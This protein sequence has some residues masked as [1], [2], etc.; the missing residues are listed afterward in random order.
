MSAIGAIVLAAGGST[1]LGRP[2][3]LAQ[4]RGRSLLRGACEAVLEAGASPVV[5]V[6]GAAADACEAELAGLPVKTARNAQWQTGMAS[7]IATGLDALAS[8]GSPADAV[9]ICLCDQPHVKAE[10]LRELIRLHESSGA[11]IVAS[12]YGGVLG[13]PAL[14]AT[15][16]FEA[17]RG[18]RGDEGARK[19]FLKFADEVRVVSHQAAAFDV[20]TPEDYERLVESASFNDARAV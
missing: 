3:Q 20:D 10:A 6:L 4:F 1:R 18:L 14:F 19:L 16:C 7:S 9:L 13:A 17:L 12:E 15:R 8:E 11:A 2:K 5:P